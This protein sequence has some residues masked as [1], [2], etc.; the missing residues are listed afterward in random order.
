VAIVK[1]EGSEVIKLKGFNID[2]EI[3]LSD[4]DSMGNYAKVDVLLPKDYLEFLITDCGLLSNL[5]IETT[6]W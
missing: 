5:S 3:L 6:V 4:S 1:V 2:G